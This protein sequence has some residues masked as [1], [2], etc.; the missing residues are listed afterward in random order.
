MVPGKIGVAF[1]LMLSAVLVRETVGH[2]AMID[3]PARNYMGMAGFSVPI[4]YDYTSQY[5]GGFDNQKTQG[6]KCGIC[7]DPWQG[8]RRH[9]PGGL[10]ATDII[11]QCYS[12]GTKTIIATIKITAWHKGYFIFKMCPHNNPK[13][14]AS[15]NCF[16]QYPLQ[17]VSGGYKYDITNNTAS[18]HNVQ[19]KLPQ[20]LTC[21]QCILQ[22]T[23]TTGHNW[24]CEG[25]KCGIGLGQQEM[26]VNC[27]DI[28]IL[29][30]CT[31]IKKPNKSQPM[32]NTTTTSS[33]GS[34]S[35]KKCRAVGE[36]AGK[37][38]M[39]KWCEDNC[40]TSKTNCKDAYCQCGKPTNPSGGSNGGKKCK[41][42]GNWTGQSSMDK[43]CLENCNAVSPQLDTMRFNCLIPQQLDTMRFNCLIPQQLDTMRFNCLIPQQLDT[44]RFNC[45]IPHQLDTMRFNCLIL[46]QLDTMR[47]N[48]L[49][50]QQL[51]TM[52]FNC[53]IPQ[54]LDT[55]R[56]NCLIPQQLDTMRFNCLIPQQLD[57]MRFN[58]LIPQQWPGEGIFHS[59]MGICSFGSRCFLYFKYMSVD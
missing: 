30:D 27:A 7:G 44:M 55:M 21:T 51:D 26:F 56:F 57:T 3:P 53:L 23:Y 11:G 43:W 38:G 39:N 29:S 34:A 35:G 14:T 32:P 19:L 12:K 9:E 16:D 50:P 45:L 1:V 2:G 5:C 17:L 31:N 42:A 41:A 6:G 18:I 58:C 25:V 24:G 4:N 33:D 8:P 22:W 28:A 10:F 49:I 13:T 59:E 20:T 15:Q 47:F 37:P 36:W 54:Q 46:Q 52:R 48:C 40:M